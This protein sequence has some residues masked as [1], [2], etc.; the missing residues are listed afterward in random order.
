M[1]RRLLTACACAT[2]LLAG[3]LVPERFS[4]RTAFQAD[5]SYEY[6]YAGTA[7]HTIA[8]TQMAKGG[9][10]AP[11]EEESLENEAAKMKHEQDIRQADYKGNARYDLS[12]EGKRQ[13]GQ[14][15]DLLGVLRVATDK[16]GVVTLAAGKLDDKEK[17]SMAKLGI[18]LD[19]T[20]SVT[21]PISAQ[22][23]SHNATS[24]P[25]FFGLIGTYRWK[26]GSIEQR[27]EMKIR[28]KQ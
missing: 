12:V 21:V 19:G 23:L 16:D 15:L 13:R 14:T 24:T 4:A 28:F 17:A 1:S 2:L 10:L 3:C 5:G 22:V 9:K 7:V 25:S 26:I 20:L 11:K 18:K 6:S 8:A 27:P